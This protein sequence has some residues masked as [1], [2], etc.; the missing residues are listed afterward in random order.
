M[1]PPSESPQESAAHR[2]AGNLLLVGSIANLIVAERAKTGGVTLGFWDFARAGVAM[3]VA[4]MA[5]ATLWPAAGGW[6]P[7]RQDAVLAPGRRNGHSPRIARGFGKG[8]HRSPTTIHRIPLL[9]PT[10]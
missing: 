6:M 10:G 4:S 2:S 1:R 5:L 3:T 7:W 8:G 9:E